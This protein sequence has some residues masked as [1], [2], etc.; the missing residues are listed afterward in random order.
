MNTSALT[1]RHAEVF[2]P[3]REP[4]RYKG[5]YGGRGSGKSHE[6]A[7][8]AVIR[9]LDQ[10]GSR[11]L[12]GRQVQ[13]SLKESAMQLVKDK[14]EG[15]GVG[16]LFE[17]QRELI[18]TPGGGVIIFQGLA[19]HTADTIKSYEGFDVFWIEEAH[20]ISE[21]SLAIIR[22]TLR[23]P[24]SELWFS[25]NPRRKSDP[26]DALLR[27]QYARE[28]GATVLKAT[29]RD[30]P[31]FPDVLKS[32]RAFDLAHSPDTYENVWE[33]DYAGVH[34]GAY[35]APYLA[36]ARRE[37]RIG[38]VAADPLVQVRA[39]WDLGVG[40]AT[41]IWVAQFVGKEIRVLEYI[42]GVGQP[43]SYFVRELRARG[44]EDALCVLPH[45]GARRDSIQ[46]I[47][48]ED[49][50]KDAGFRVVTIANQGA[51]A[52]RLRI[53]AMRR[54][55]GKMWF[56]ETTTEGGREALGFYHEKLDQERGIGLGPEHDWSSHGA[57]AAGL[58]A[59]AYDPPKI[60]T[61]D[62]ARVFTTQG[63]DT[64]AW[65]AS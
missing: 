30:N 40:D 28:L 19:D 48:Y 49:H 15:L 57:D 47:K 17:P 20:T 9:C 60:R 21:G 56:N 10:P 63:G 14:I 62:K 35:F 43:L 61:A 51:G 37:G 46:A 52:A 12:C 54:L 42:E 5:S 2:W 65:M 11:I 23:A 18:K 38:H 7:T 31:W 44:W 6:F 55:F 8:N 4:S 25:W 1:V 34:K 41:A 53:E 29:W 27:G 3:F 58:M 26:V 39:F 33:G 36:A 32:E 16:G 50:L 45:D 64:S 24:G 13:K 59:I 22:P